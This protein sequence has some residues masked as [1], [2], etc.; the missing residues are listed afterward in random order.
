MRAPSRRELLG[1][2]GAFALA[3]CGGGA[4][5]S[6]PAWVDGAVAGVRRG[7]AWLAAQQAP[8]GLLPGQRYG[9][10]AAGHSI[11]ALVV[12]C[13]LDLPARVEADPRVV[14]RAFVGLRGARSPEG[15]LGLLGP[16]VDYPVYAT[17]LA[18]SSLARSRPPAWEDDLRP[19]LGWLRSQQ[20]LAGFDG[21][22]AHG[23][24]PLGDRTPPQPRPDLHVDLSMTRRAVEALVDAGV[25]LADPSLVAARAFVERCRAP[26]GGF[27]YT[28]VDARLNKAGCAAGPDGPVCAGYGSATTDGVLALRA[29]G[30]TDLSA[31]LE[32]LGPRHRVDVNPGLDGGP[33]APFARAMRGYWRAG[34]ARVYYEVGGPGEWSESMAAAILQEQRPDGAWANESPL[35][36]EDEPAIATAFALSALG[37]AIQSA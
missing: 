35:Q 28:P 12:R 2:A 17:A 19:M 22:P 5:V 32:W 10:M 27:V 23:G 3:A 26:G 25:A 11:T 31:E 7:L 21:H 34:A 4:V 1:A 18:C 6:G 30:V 37:H 16:V 13:L 24:W 9:F 20:C 33:M 29:L 14:G 8:S 15:A 36:K